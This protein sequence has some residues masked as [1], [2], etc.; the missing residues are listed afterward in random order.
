MKSLLRALSFKSIP[1]APC[2]RITCSS[3]Y[4]TRLFTE[5]IREY[6]L[7]KIYS[8]ILGY[9]WICLTK[10][11]VSDIL[12][13]ELIFEGKNQGTSVAGLCV[14]YIEDHRQFQVTETLVKKYILVSRV[15]ACPCFICEPNSYHFDTCL[16]LSPCVVIV[17]IYS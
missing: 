2:Q 14:I 15:L 7:S 3:R 6:I 9:Y 4:G 13:F 10:K 16:G 1:L 12:Q 8:Y 17:L 5:F 11:F